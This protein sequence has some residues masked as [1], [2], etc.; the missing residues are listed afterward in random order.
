M[1][2]PHRTSGG[3]RQVTLAAA[4][5]RFLSAAV[6]HASVRLGA[7]LV[8]R[9]QSAVEGCFLLENDGSKRLPGITERARNR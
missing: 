9:R 4:R 3:L 1:K 8:T 7:R 5:L 6:R 2:A